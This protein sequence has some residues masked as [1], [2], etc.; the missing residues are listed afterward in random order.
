MLKLS[1]R[2]Q[3]PTVYLN[4]ASPYSQLARS[5]SVQVTL[6]IS[7]LSAFGFPEASGLVSIQHRSLA[8]VRTLPPPPSAGG[9]HVVS[10]LVGFP[11]PCNELKLVPVRL[12][13]DR[14]TDPVQFC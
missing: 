5:R 1:G 2:E 14:P 7:L 13:V 12:G 11:L 10:N 6:T 4:P 9:C 8:S 3:S